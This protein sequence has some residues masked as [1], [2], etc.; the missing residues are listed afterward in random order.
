MQSI[1]YVLLAALPG[2]SAKGCL[3]GLQARPESNVAH[4]DTQVKLLRAWSQSALPTGKTALNK[5]LRYLTEAGMSEAE[6]LRSA[7][8]VPSLWHIMTGRWSIREVYRADLLL[9][10]LGSD[11]L[12]N[13][14][15]TLDIARVWVGGYEHV[16]L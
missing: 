15:Q 8:I 1:K 3:P 16:S 6:A 4:I 9:L 7:T 12:R 11:P 5:E 13:I 10:R 2:S 14:S